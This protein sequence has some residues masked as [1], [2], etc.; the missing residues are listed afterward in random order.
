MPME[1]PQA[2]DSTV[3]EPL[4][5][6]LWK[7]VLPAIRRA[8]SVADAHLSKGGWYPRVRM[9]HVADLES[10]WPYLREP[11][12]FPPDD[13][14]VAYAELFTSENDGLSGLTYADIDEFAALYE[15]VIRDRGLRERL[16]PFK[17]ASEE[18]SDR[19]VEYEAA[20]L[21]LSILDRA[22]S[23]GKTTDDDYLSLY[24]QRERAW[25]LEA[26]PVE[27]VIPLVLTE[28]PLEAGEIV[29]I[30]PTVSLVRL[31]RND[32]LARAVSNSG[33]SNVPDMVVGAAKYAIVLSGHQ[34][35]NL[36]P[37]QRLVKPPEAPSLTD[38]DM[39]C[40]ALRILTGIDTGYAQVLCRPVGW[41]DTWTYDLPVLLQ[42]GTYRRY[43]EKFDRFGWMGRGE[44]VSREELNRLPMLVAALRGAPAK[45]HLAA[46]RLSQAALR[47]SDDDRIIDACIGLE[48]LLGE[49]RDELSH[50][51]ALRA[52]TALASRRD[53]A[54]NPHMIYDLM[55]KIY[56]YRSIVVHGSSSVKSQTIDVNGLLVPAASLSV[57]LLRELL[58][59]LLSGVELWT[60]KSLDSRLLDA[61]G[62]ERSSADSADDR[63]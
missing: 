30:D 20:A 24:I 3:D 2:E 59:D 31:E 15:Y 39:V 25:L 18:R 27:Y 42:I 40:D 53:S 11:N 47:D 16:W 57:I 48:A 49:G 5:P 37:G 29:A 12:W 62:P 33:T 55:K 28:L 13:A 34:W 58:K 45:V 14:P 4:D 23:I 1:E 54:F 36:G 46:R 35:A 63:E 51:L 19:M 50:R 56:N 7:L 21:P 44:P 38:V 6:D 8:A 61:L 60:A 10:G 9:P 43:P 41:A 26:L 32:H 17:G 52:A 22:R